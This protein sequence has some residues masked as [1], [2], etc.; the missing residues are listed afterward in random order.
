MV[1]NTTS[2]NMSKNVG[3]GIVNVRAAMDAA[4]PNTNPPVAAF[5]GS[6]TTGDITLSVTFTDQS[7]NSPTSWSWSFGDGGSSTAQNPSYDYTVAGTYTV[8]L[9][10]T[11]AYGN[12]TDTKTNYVTAT[13]PSNDPPVADFT[14]NTTSGDA[15]LSVN[16]SDLSTNAPTSWSWTFGDGGSS[17][18]QNPGYT[19]TTAGTYT[20]SLTATNAFG[21]DAKT[22]NGYITVTEPPVG[23][24]VH[25]HDIA[26]SRASKGPNWNGV[27]RITIY[28]EN[29]QPAANV[30]VSVT[31]TGPTGGTGTA[32][33]NASGVVS[34]QTSKTKNP[35]G[36]WCFE[37]TNVTH[38]TDSYNSTGNEVTKACESGVVFSEGGATV[39]G[40]PDTYGL[41]QNY[42][43]P[44]NPT[45]EI[46]FSL[47]AAVDSKKMLLLK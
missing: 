2:Y 44:F 12:D 33:T 47:A 41:D 32:T 43:N 17:T 37:V 40:L 46:S 22:V 15:P 39:F 3:V 34:F 35:S 20:V 31:A 6:P 7:A 27:G 45:T 13:Q 16:F 38:A 18:T 28:D 30:S 21:S 5:S 36:E 4:G 23:G 29:E 24:T 8:S 14:S 10:V 26:V 42:P 11:N 25:V 1:Q 19:Y 9:T